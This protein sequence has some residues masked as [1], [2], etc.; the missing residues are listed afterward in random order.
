MSPILFFLPIP[1]TLVAL[2]VATAAD[3]AAR[4]G[5]AG[6][7]DSDSCSAA[8]QGRYRLFKG[9]SS[10]LPNYSIKHQKQ[11]QTPPKLFEAHK[12]ETQKKTELPS[13]A[14]LF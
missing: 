5:L 7:L 3:W 14:S 12:G 6:L 8:A 4:P 11:Q 2:T 1:V 13:T 9:R 10:R